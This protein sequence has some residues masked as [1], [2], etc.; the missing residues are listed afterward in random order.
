MATTT[1]NQ[2]RL[3][4]A[5]RLKNVNIWAVALS[6]ATQQTT[7][8]IEWIGV[9]APSTVHSDT[10]MGNARPLHVFSRPPPNASNRWWSIYNQNEAEVLFEV[11]APQG[12]IIDIVVNFKLQ[13]DEGAMAAPAG[14]GAGSTVGVIYAGYLDGFASKQLSPIS[15]NPT[16]P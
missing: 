9:N 12:A 3:F 5:V 16:L 15:G 10:T 2:F 1:T 11:T 13:D 7:A 6:S 8:A 4:G 14:T